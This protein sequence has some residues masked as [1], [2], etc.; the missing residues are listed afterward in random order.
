MSRF[1]FQI[2]SEISYG[3]AVTDI[4]YHFADK[5]FVRRH[6]SVFHKFAEIVAKY[7]AEIMMA[8]VRKERTAVGKH[9]DKRAEMPRSG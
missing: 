4:F 3:V 8:G 6:F 1:L 5:F 9:A 2:D 7:S